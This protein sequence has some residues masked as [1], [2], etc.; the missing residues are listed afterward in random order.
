MKRLSENYRQ[1]KKVGKVYPL[2]KRT[3]VRKL[4]TNINGKI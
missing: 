4:K 1:N 2:I 3:L